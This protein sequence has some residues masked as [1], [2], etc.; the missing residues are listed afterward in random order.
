[1][2]RLSLPSSRRARWAV[3]VVAAVALAG[4]GPLATTLT[5]SAQ[6]SLP[7][8][9][10]AQLLVDVQRARVQALSGTVVET[11]ALGLPAV[12]GVGGRGGAS[13]SSLVS[14]SHTMRLWYAGPDQVRL[15]LLGQLGE[16]D[17]VRTGSD[18]WAWSSDTNTATHWTA[19][20]AGSSGPTGPDA[21]AAP[22]TPQQAADAAL[23]AIDPSTRVTTDPTAVVAGRSAYELVLTPRDSRS[24]VGSVRIAVD[25]TTHIPTRVQVFARGATAPAFEVGFTSFS[26]STPPASTFAFTPPPG[27]TVKQGSL[28]A[29]HDVTGSRAQPSG[30]T[31]SVVGTGWTTVV[32]A[33]VGSMTGGQTNQSSP[34]SLAGLLKS[35]PAVS[36]A[37]GSG[38]LLHGALF[39]A[40][41]T[42]DGRVAVGAVP[43]SMLY[44]ALAHG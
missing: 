24:T 44:A 29:P 1:M 23:K 26:T 7:P 43:P 31:P 34:G 38:H 30:A 8:R 3:P 18:V 21:A 22:V 33:D 36:G 37:W 35:L 17:L 4:V 15:A 19:P 42:D 32:V 16:S 12:P 11:S 28:T 41:L 6:G 39:S 40:V 5:A 27:A 25:G 10:A 9:T 14:G 20:V 13:F 2:A